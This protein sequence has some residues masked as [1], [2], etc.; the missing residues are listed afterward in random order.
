MAMNRCQAGFGLLEA[1]LA[2]AIGLMLLGAAS[3][4]FVSAYHAWQ[5]QSVA[6]RLQDD[7]RLALQRMA[8]DIR[9]AGMFGCLRQD[10]IVFESQ[11]AAEAFAQP[12]QI[13]LSGNGRLES[14]GLVGEQLPGTGRQ[15]DWVLLT[16]CL[17]WAEVRH[18][19]P[20][21]SGAALVVP[22]QRVTYQLH[23]D[24]LRLGRAGQ[25]QALIDRVRDL[26][27]VLVPTHQGGRVDLQLTLFDPQHQVELRHEVSVALRN[28]E[29]DV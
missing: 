19:P 16:D 8:Q 15:P 26:R 28:G 17:S 5:V 13:T 22:I 11:A 14:L 29:P 3:Q 2:L 20:P 1:L 18:R 25:A 9:M 7:A 12:L 24:T 27:V 4:L 6:V 21:G 23:G 10:A